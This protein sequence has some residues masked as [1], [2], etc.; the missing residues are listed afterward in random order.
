MFDPLLRQWEMA[1]QEFYSLK[2]TS[3]K[4]SYTYV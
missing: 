1:G 3:Y 2:A 4:L